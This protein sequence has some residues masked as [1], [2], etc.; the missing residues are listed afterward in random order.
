MHFYLARQPVFDVTLKVIA[1]ELLYRGGVGAQLN[2]QLDNDAATSSLVIETVMKL[3]IGHVT[4]GAPALIN[5]SRS[6]LLDQTF[7]L[8]SSKDFILEILETTVVDQQLVERVKQLKAKGIRIALD[9]FEYAEQWEPLIELADIIKIDVLAMTPER[10][11][12]TL[13]KLS[14]FQGKLL[15]EKVE[16]YAVYE[17]Y[18]SMG[19]DYFQGYFLAHPKLLKKKNIATKNIVYCELLALLF[20]KTSSYKTLVKLIADS[21]KL[22]EQLLKVV[23]ALSGGVRTGTTPQE[24][25]GAEGV[26][27]ISRL[28]ALLGLTG[29]ENKPS[30]LI[31]TAW[32]RSAMCQYLAEAMGEDGH[33]AFAVGLLSVFEALMDVPI[34]SLFERWHFDEQIIR[35]VQEFEGATGEILKM[36]LYYEAGDWDS[37]VVPDSINLLDI[38][39]KALHFT[40]IGMIEYFSSH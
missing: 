9:D 7:S 16:D 38:Y 19:F 12:Q 18:K 30:E 1:Y 24:V 26:K 25:I 35:A 33:K 36:V 4:G 28:A 40:E 32:I 15:A 27:S 34:V 10:V 17:Q 2:P 6:L 22:S 11:L 13:A 5:V 39:L 20:E 29:A 3:G 8:C 14:G 23:H 31:L 21:P 37:I